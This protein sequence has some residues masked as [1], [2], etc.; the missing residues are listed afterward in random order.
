M[1]KLLMTS[2]LVLSMAFAG[3]AM[4]SDEKHADAAKHEKSDE[5]HSKSDDSKKKDDSH[6]S[7]DHDKKDSREKP[8]H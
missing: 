3:S 4:T 6:K 2:L 1:K 5:K 8:A 7:A